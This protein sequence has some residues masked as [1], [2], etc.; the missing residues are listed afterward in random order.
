M[1]SSIQLRKL[2]ESFLV[3]AFITPIQP[4]NI[5]YLLNLQPQIPENDATGFLSVHNATVRSVLALIEGQSSVLPASTQRPFSTLLARETI[6]S[7]IKD[8]QENL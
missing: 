2:H 8:T 4:T 6:I 5:N 7:V 3:I 1:R